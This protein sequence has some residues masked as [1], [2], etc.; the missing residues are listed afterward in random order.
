MKFDRNKK[1]A[2]ALGGGGATERGKVRARRAEYGSGC[3][4]YKTI[5][6]ELGLYR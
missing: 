5:T 3:G 6:I 4:G 2:L 1:Y